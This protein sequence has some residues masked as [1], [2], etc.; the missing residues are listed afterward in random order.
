M[1][2]PIKIGLDNPAF[3]G[4]LKHSHRSVNRRPVS[5]TRNRFDTQILRAGNSQPPPG[6]SPPLQTY[7]ESE[8]P[9]KQ[10]FKKLNYK[11]SR[12]QL[13]LMSMSALILG[14]G[15]T[16]SIQAEQVN[17]RAATQV[18]A[19]SKKVDN[20][21]GSS[22]SNLPSTTKPSSS[23]INS[24]IVAPDLAR[25]LKI[26][27]I[28]VF[29]RVMQVGITSGGALGTPNNVYD[30]AWY[31]G[32][33]EPG[34]TGATLIDG[35][36]SSWTTHG[37]F[38]NLDKLKAGDPISIVRGDGQVINYQVV[39]T[40]TY[41]YNQVDMNAALTPVTPGKSGLNLIT[42]TGQVIKGTSQFNKRLIVFASQV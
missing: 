25:Y 40:I 37:V 5:Y 24:Y 28:N 38:Y 15:I 3:R 16:I 2:E 23:A 9:K 41:N 20:Q 42:C 22:N 39:K 1:S 32:S 6:N 12:G 14:F 21:S 18:A 4:R 35:H 7:Y 36:V 19:L 31:S 10:W 34:Q 17:H 13:A 8:K 11:Y 26:P 29:A 30:T 33:A 27:E